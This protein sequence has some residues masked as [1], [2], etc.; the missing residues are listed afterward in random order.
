MSNLTPAWR[1]LDNEHEPC[2]LCGDYCPPDPSEM[3][4]RCA[5]A[6]CP[7]GAPLDWAPGGAELR[8]SDGCLPPGSS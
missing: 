4:P 5:A 7:C 1:A 6:P 2:L 8:C 3:C